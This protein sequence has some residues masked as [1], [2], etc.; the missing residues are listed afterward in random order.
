M[1]R[2]LT[3]VLS[4]GLVA[5]GVTVLAAQAPAAADSFETVGS[6]CQGGGYLSLIHI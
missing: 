2:S 6:S 3:R 5:G 1:I 4:L